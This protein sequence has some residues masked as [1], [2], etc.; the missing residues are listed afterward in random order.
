MS[1]KVSN[2]RVELEKERRARAEGQTRSKSTL[3][4]LKIYLLGYN[5]V[6][7]LLWANL[8]YITISFLLTGRPGSPTSTSYW[9]RMVHSSP[10]ARRLLSSLPPPLGTVSHYLSGSYNYKNLGWLTKWTQTLAVLEVVHAALGWV[11]SPILTTA[12]QVASRVYTVWGVVEAV[13]KVSLTSN[14]G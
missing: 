7:A 9:T 12:S 13:P 3:S 4:P 10:L 5:V 14:R 1:G 11:R 6:S 8:L 2:N